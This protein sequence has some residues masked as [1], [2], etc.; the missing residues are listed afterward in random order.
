M[1]KCA[2]VGTKP[3]QERCRSSAQSHLPMP[4]AVS[5]WLWL[6]RKALSS[7]TTHSDADRGGWYILAYGS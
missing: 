5:T 1:K 3:V 7:T 6:L 4:L 2:I